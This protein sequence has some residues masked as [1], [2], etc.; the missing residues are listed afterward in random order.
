VSAVD[1]SIYEFAGGEPAFR[2]LAE[3]H[4]RR[5][6]ADPVLNHP[7]SHDDGRPDHVERLG[8]YWA[9]VLGGPPLYTE[10]YGGHGDVLTMHAMPDDLTDLGRRFLDCFVAALDDAGLPEDAAFRA[11]MRAYMTWAVGDVLT[12]SGPEAQ[13]V[14]ASRR[15]PRWTWDGLA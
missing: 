10:R 5:C 11:A 6:L 14:G 4:H 13:P 2:A 9:E 7:F 3:A 8:R 12:V 15:L 1:G